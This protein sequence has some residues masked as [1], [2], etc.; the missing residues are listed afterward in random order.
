ME[1][2]RMDLTNLTDL[3]LW[4]Y[5]IK[6]AMTVTMAS[7]MT[8]KKGLLPPL[9]QHPGGFCENLPWTS[10]QGQF[11]LLPKNKEGKKMC[12]AKPPGKQ[13]KMLKTLSKQRI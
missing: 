11:Y 12:Q 3:T 10:W 2:V 1:G 9:V 6:I 5:T 7:G 4:A 8:T 13:K